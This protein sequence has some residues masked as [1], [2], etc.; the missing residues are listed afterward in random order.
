MKK[1]VSIILVFISAVFMFSCHKKSSPS[2]PSVSDTATATCTWTQ[3]DTATQTPSQTCTPS[4]TVTSTATA[5]PTVTN[6][7]TPGPIVIDDYEDGDTVNKIA[8]SDCVND[9]H[10]FCMVPCSH[11]VSGGLAWLDKGP[12]NGNYYYSVTGTASF[13]GDYDLQLLMATITTSATSTGISI[14]DMTYLNFDY[15]IK[16]TAALKLEI[17]I[18][19][20]YGTSLYYALNAVSDNTWQSASIPL[21]AFTGTP[22][23][24]LGNVYQVNINTN[25]IAPSGLSFYE[26]FSLDNIKFT[27]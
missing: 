13:G 7:H 15:K 4:F 9:T 26:E 17:K 8:C 12:L 16:A 5:T 24:V 20:P 23:A 10:Y 3:Q 6:T 25:T 22:G 2:S 18:Y 11:I 19:N 1:V 27:R 14:T 21:S